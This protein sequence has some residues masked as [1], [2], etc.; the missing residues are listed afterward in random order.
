MRT[1]VGTVYETRIYRVQYTAKAD[2]IET[3]KDLF[4]EGSTDSE[5]DECFLEVVDRNLAPD[6]VMEWEA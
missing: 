5:D 3:A 2:D 6:T 1:Y 4:R